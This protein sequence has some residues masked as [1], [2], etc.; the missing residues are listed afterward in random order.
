M[1]DEPN[2]RNGYEPQEEPAVS[3]ALPPEL[4]AL[5]ARL[6]ADGA[7]WQH[8]LPD[9]AVIAERI[10]AIPGEASRDAHHRRNLMTL[11]V[12]TWPGGGPQDPSNTDPDLN[13]RRPSPPGG[14]GRFLGLV[15]AVVVVGLLATVLARLASTSSGSGPAP[16]PA[17]THAPPTQVQ[18][19]QPAPSPTVP[20]ATATPTA[21][22]H[23]V[24]V[25]FSKRPD[26][27]NDPSAVFPVQRTA[28]TLAVATYAIGQLIAGPTPSEAAAGY[29]TEL[30]AALSGPS[31]CGGADFTITLDRRGAT[32]QTGTATLR[33]CR[34]LSLP[35]E[36]TDAR[37]SAEITR[38][39][40]QF[41]NIT[42]VVILTRDGHCF[43]DLSGADRCLQ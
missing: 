12:G 31:D 23:P 14:R 30:S 26:S 25:Y 40:A 1:N 17:P 35:G 16:H 21:A 3:A 43:G 34:A 11:D 15:A 2:A 7:H 38:T 4:E 18:P 42:A 6:A 37:I 19:T 27:L 33:F 10:R 22:G 36:L 20:A 13:R 9:P 24:L 39:L 29:F 8:R 32:P 41:S 28:P 5:A